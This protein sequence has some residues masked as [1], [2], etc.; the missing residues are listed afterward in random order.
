MDEDGS[1][2]DAFG[3]YVAPETYL[4]D[5]AGTI[6]FKHSSSM[7]REV[8]ESEFLPRISDAEFDPVPAPID[9]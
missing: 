4:I 5:A 3:L 9:R 7:T 6:I 8:W 1:V 2:G